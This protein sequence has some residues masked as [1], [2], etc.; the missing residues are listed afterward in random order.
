MERPDLSQVDPL[1]RAYIEYLEKRLKIGYSQK[2][3]SVAIEIP[4]TPIPPESPTTINIVTISKEGYA[5]RTYRHLYPR[6][7]RGGMG[8]FDID[9]AGDDFPVVLANAEEGQNILLF[10]NKARVYRQNL[11]KITEAS[12]HSRGQL[13]FDRSPMDVDEYITVVLPEQA[14]GYIAMLTAQGRV[15][16]LRHHLFGEHMRP[17]TQVFKYEEFG[18]LVSACWTPGD[19]E[20]FITSKNG[21]AIRF[22]EKLVSPQGD[23]GI[24]LGDQDTAV[25]IASVGPEDGVF[26]L[27][28]NGRGTI[29]LMSGFAPNKSPGGSG[30]I[31]MKTE[32]LIGAVKIVEEDEIFIISRFGKIIRFRVDEVPASEGAVQGVNCMGLRGD[33][34]VTLLKSSPVLQSTGLF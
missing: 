1:V 3:E 14:S 30:K 22:G 15:R 25:S 23:W 28:S 2:E 4:D 9:M 21:Q 5:K 33:E 16:C 18:A 7:H 31:A 24:R 17:G 12:L 20:L 34:V 11:S 10:T 26:L 8:I 19:S 32:H 29:R 13:L 6:Q 27:T